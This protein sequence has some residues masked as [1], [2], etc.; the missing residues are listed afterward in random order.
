MPEVNFNKKISP[1]VAQQTELSTPLDTQEQK[2][3]LPP[4]LSR[5]A[6][7]TVSD[8]PMDLEALVNK[9]NLETTDA[10]ENSARNTLQSVFATVIAKAE[11]RGM[12]STRNM[13]LLAQAQNY[14]QQL[15]STNTAIDTLTT[16]ISQLKEIVNANEKEVSKK[17]SQIDSLA[18]DLENLQT[19]I[20]QKNAGITILQ[21]EIDSLTRQIEN[22]VNAQKLTNLKR[23]LADEQKKLETE[24]EDLNGLQ[25]QKET[26]LANLAKARADLAAAQ[27]N[28]GAVKATLTDA[29]GVLGVAN[30]AKAELNQ[31]IQQ[32]LA[33]I[34]DDSIIRDIANALKINVADVAS[35]LTNVAAERG[36]EEENYLEAHSPVLILQNALNEHYQEIL[37][38][39]AAKRENM[40]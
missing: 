8:A 16:Q 28:L 29:E 26:N 30:A 9:L 3:E 7:L 32:A 6:N 1:E 11:E 10:K 5:T 13:E 40:V 31:K 33:E 2:K 20:Q 15:D 12:V 18:K 19:K 38:T 35:F 34:T 22:E 37:D 36:V 24:M 17:Q 14:S 27:A 23:R 21:M 39:I 4:L 25:A